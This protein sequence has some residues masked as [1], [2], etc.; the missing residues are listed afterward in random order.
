MIVFRFLAIVFLIFC[1]GSCET[2]PSVSNQASAMPDTSPIVTPVSIEAEY[3]KI[4][5]HEAQDIISDE[6]IVLAVCTQEEFDRGHI[7]QA[8]L[9][10][11]NEIREKTDSTLANKGQTILVYSRT[12]ERSADAARVLIDM[13]Y[14]NVLDFGGIFDWPGEIVRNGTDTIFYNYFGGNLPDDIVTTTDYSVTKR[15]HSQLPTFIFRFECESVQKYTLNYDKS[16]YFLWYPTCELL[17]LIITDE[18]GNLVQE[19]TNVNISNDFSPGLEELTFDDWNFDGY[20]DFRLPNQTLRSYGYFLWDSLNNSYVRNTELEE[21]GE[22]SP[23][24]VDHENNR[25]EVSDGRMGYY[26]TKY[27]NYINGV[28]TM[29]KLIEESD[30][31]T[32]EEYLVRH[33]VVS[34]LV[35]G[36]MVIV[37]EY[38]ESWQEA[39]ANLLRDYTKLSDDLFFLLYDFDK[40]LTPELIV[41][42]KIK[43]EMFDAVY[44]YRDSKAQ[45]LEYSE[46]VF[47]ADSILYARGG[48]KAAPDNDPGLIDYY[49]GPSAGYFGTDIWYNRIVIDENKLV[50]DAYGKRYVDVNTLNTLFD[51]FGRDTDDN[52]SLVTVIQE[53]THY[54]INDKAVSEDELYRMFETKEDDLLPLRITETNISKKLFSSTDIHD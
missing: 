27:Y 3:K 5:P 31:I 30:E 39:Y 42:G 14:T 54:Y 17:R 29:V 37:E 34:E 2:A 18:N 33:F 10:P 9:L 45:S 4:T 49:I 44:T 7:R 15:I 35:G 46:D 11:D 25:I 52:T 40:D 23:L 43:D 41:A 1:L 51:N 47:T 16:L 38:T 19:I 20:L 6:V 32:D 24:S 50:I 48:V 26:T 36:E 12:E 28:I 22:R 8:I 21:L 13:G 53:H